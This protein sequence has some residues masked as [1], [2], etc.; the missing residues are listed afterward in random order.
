MRKLFWLSV[1]IAIAFV[2][3][4]LFTGGDY[5]R[6]AAEKTGFNLYSVAHFADTLRVDD[7][8]AGKTAKSKADEKRR[9]GF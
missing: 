9:Y 1:L 4:S 2:V 8:M 3:L 6:L 5:I 7:W